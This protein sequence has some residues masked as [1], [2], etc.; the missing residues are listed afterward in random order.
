VGGFGSGRYRRPAK[1]TVEECLFLDI[2]QARRSGLIGKSQIPVFVKSS[3]FPWGKKVA[4]ITFSIDESNENRP[5]LTLKYEV[6][7][8]GKRKRIREPVPLQATQPY[9]GGDR[10]W[11]TCP[12]VVDGQPCQRRV[13][14]LYIPPGGTYFGCRHCHDLTYRSCQESH[15][16]DWLCFLVAEKI[17]RATPEKVK[18]ALSLLWA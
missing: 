11:F 6:D 18:R 7:Q 12:L 14:K 2:N 17:P 13:G 4:M 1:W 9:F 16:R 5:I 15:K 8:E 10:W 3:Y